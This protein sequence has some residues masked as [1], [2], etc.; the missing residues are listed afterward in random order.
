MYNRA[1][2]DAQGK[3]WD[4]TRAGIVW[5]GERW[6]G[7][8]PDIKPDSPPGQFGAFIMLPEGVARLFAPS[9]NDGPFPEH[10]EAIEAPV[11]NPLHAK[12][13]SSPVAKRFSTDKDKYGDRKEYPIVCTTYRLTEHF[14]FWT[15]HHKNGRLNEVQPGF[16]FEIPEGL[17]KEKGIKNGERIRVSSARGSIEGPAVVTKRIWQMKIDGQQVWQIGLPIHWGYAGDSKH[18]GP[19]A[20]MLTPSAMDANTWTPEFKA[21]QVKVEKAAER[22]S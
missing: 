20:N 14:H 15:Q 17:A 11:D 3:A 21:F 5:N 22:V 7:D 12:N 2:A 16:F 4:P 18:V 6:V 1:S 8:V 19:L 10:Y 9:L 13:S